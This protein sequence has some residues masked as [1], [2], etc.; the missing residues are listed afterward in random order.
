[1]KAER[2][3]WPKNEHHPCACVMR[4]KSGFE[5]G[6]VVPDKS[7]FGLYRGKKSSTHVK[8]GTAKTREEAQALAGQLREARTK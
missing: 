5:Y 6:I 7:R 1:M 8:A 3:A 2:R 4:H